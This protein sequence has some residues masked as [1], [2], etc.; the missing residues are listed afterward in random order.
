MSTTGIDHINI[1][2]NDLEETITFYEAVL[3]LTRGESPAAAMG[4][5]GAW[6]CDAAGHA[7]IHLIGNEPGLRLG[8]GRAPGQS[9]NAVHHIAFACSGFD[10][11]KARI[12]S[13][14]RPF[15]VN[16]GAYGLRQI[17]ISDPNAVSVEMNFRD[18]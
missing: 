6:M 1:L 3:G 5:Q 12:A 16:D 17:M 10:A 8:E 13:T 15:H 4:I 14:G 7:L 18:D 9:T 11:A 2:A